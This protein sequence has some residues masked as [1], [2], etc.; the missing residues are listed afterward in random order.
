MPVIT[1][2]NGGETLTGGSG[3]DTITGG[4]GN[5]QIL[6]GDGADSI[7]GG[8]GND[9]INGYPSAGGSYSYWTY[10]GT[11]TINGGNG[12]DFIY[13]ADGADSLVGGPG[14][15]SI[16]GSLDDDTLDGGLGN[17]DL[18][19]GAGN[20]LLYGGE[21]ND[22]LY[23]NEGTDTIYGGLGNDTLSKYLAAGSSYLDGG[24]GDDTIWGSHG[25]D[26]IIGGD[27]NDAWLEGY[28][29]NDSISGGNGN[30]KLYGDEG[31]DTL[32]GGSG[33]DYLG[34]GDG[35]D[36]LVGGDG[37]D[38]IN[39]GSG[40]DFIQAGAGDDDVSYTSDT[41]DD[42]V[43]GGEGNDYVNYS[44]IN[45]NKVIYGES[46]ND[47][48]YGGNGNDSLDGGSG[49]DYLGGGDGN[50][51][52]YVD[53][54][55]DYIY[56]S[57]G[58][59]TAY[60]STS[61]VKLP[62]S[63]E[64]VNYVNGALA[65]P[66]WIDA[67]LPDQTAGLYFKSI[68][69]SSTTVFY[70]FPNAIPSYDT[71]AN[72][73]LGYSGFTSLQ[74]SRTK[75]ALSNLSAFLNLQFTETTNPAQNNTISF[76]N[77]T[78]TDSGGYARF[79]SS[80][81]YSASD[82][83]LNKS[84]DTTY[85]L[86]DGEYQTLTL[87]HE[88]GHALGLEHPFSTPGSGGELADPPYLTGSEDSTTWTIMS[89]TDSPAQYYLQYS[90]LDIAALQYLYGPSKTDRAGNDT[91]RILTS[92]PNFVWDGAGVD[93]IDAS[94]VGQSTTIYLTPGYQGFVGTTKAEKITT[95]GQITVNFGSVIENLIGSN[96]DDHLYGNEVGNSIQ[97]G[98]GND[99]IEGWDGDDTL[100]GG[101]G[102]DY[103]TG[104]SGNDS[105]E[106][107]DGTDTL[108]VNGIASNY[109]I[110]YDTAL[111]SYSIET[112]VGAEGKDTFKSVEFVKYSDKTVAIQSIDIT[113]PTI[114]ITSD[115][116]SL[117]A[118]KKANLTFTLS[119]ASTTFTSSDIRVTGG[120]LSNFAGTNLIYTAV[121]TPNAN[122]T[123]N[124]VI[125]VASGVFTDIAGNANAD[126][127]DLNNTVTLS[128][129][130]A[131]PTI[132]VSANKLALISGEVAA[133]T[134]TLS[135]S[136][137]SFTVSDVNVAGGTLS[138]FSGNAFT[139]TALFTPATNST[140]RGTASVASGV[141]TDAAGNLNAD[142]SDAN[143]TLSIAIDTVPPTIAISSNKS[144]LQVGDTATL[145]FTL[146]EASTNF[147]ASDL[148]V[149][150]GTLA[151]FSGSG[152]TY[153]A[154]FTL[155][156]FI[157]LNGSVSVASGA[158]SDSA[159]NTNADG[160][161]AN[162]AVGF[163]RNPTVTNETHALSVI[164]DKNV[165]GAS[166]ILL[167]DL[168]ESITYTN[169]SITK[170]SIEYA[171]VTLDY[172]L[173]DVFFTTVTRD[174]EFTAEFTKEINDYVKSDLNITY[175]A[176]VSLLGVANIDGVLLSVA[177]ADGN[178]VG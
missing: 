15:D 64:K 26:T 55:F 7:E 68:L 27:G 17:D 87:V 125:S 172:K 71:S 59:D 23:G 83:Y 102:N 86:R 173:V 133:L 155:S 159:G 53:S 157:L 123:V 89:Y 107:G 170:H 77:N 50:D 171:G 99:S 109:T 115:V 137:T 160:A 101:A 51:T 117:G 1:G 95:A 103:L 14:N 158:F 174:G 126:G 124:G 62:S 9:Q 52:Y 111:K 108:V 22:S 8:D 18:S 139:Y 19:G 10:A 146:S 47:S 12:D 177:G 150:G 131:A 21:G 122:S 70:A 74:I 63:I 33:N 75:E 43:Y 105:I 154:S 67:L 169:D 28:L 40:N 49:N 45:G 46:G 168:K 118:D 54:T 29:G 175:A 76:A 41:G 156:P 91:Y 88:L 92:A 2:K 81:Y 73:A 130:T 132:A 97:G 82:V 65:L 135:E 93:V 25:N 128:V 163:S 140:I 106:G 80:G 36:S 11:K 112:K 178:F 138:N 16:Y 39:G 58:Y 120:T 57:A 31:S 24:V 114:A 5:D 98:A 119:E 104:G 136:S 35:N 149:I 110:A 116:A 100:L 127:I 60:V 78:Q 30:D 152:T 79:P 166:A 48:L 66:Y 85:T 90:A 129:D 167:K 142:G 145:S 13:G 147:T 37:N 144:N 38:S 3:S 84:T 44:E 20:D 94:S 165:L 61:F 148:A 34:G 121:F 162:N 4:T 56:D 164:V 96:S 176:A 32:D 72:N 69:G 42:T 153:T 134:F 113:P 161:D 6:S 141:F 143:N 151:N